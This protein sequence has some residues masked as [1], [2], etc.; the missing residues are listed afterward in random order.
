MFI[1]FICEQNIFGRCCEI[2]L[3]CAEISYSYVSVLEA[4]LIKCFSDVVDFNSIMIMNATECFEKL[5]WGTREEEIYV[6]K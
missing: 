3:M 5:T 1:N 2:I 4:F 6:W